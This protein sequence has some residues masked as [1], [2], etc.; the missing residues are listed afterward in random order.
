M[1]CG[2][3]KSTAIAESQQPQTKPRA[4][5][6]NSPP[7][8]STIKA[9]EKNTREKS[10]TST[11]SADSGISFGDDTP[12]TTTTNRTI[13]SPQR[14]S[15]RPQQPLPRDTKTST[16]GVAFEISFGDD[17]GA[18]PRRRL[19]PRLK[20]LERRPEREFSQRDI[21]AKLARADELRQKNRAEKAARSQIESEKVE[22]VHTHMV[23][24]KTILGDS[25]LEEH[26]VAMK[27]R[28]AHL[29]QLRAKLQQQ[30]GRNLQARR[31]AV[32]TH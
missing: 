19:P 27:E 32:K 20:S 14:L 30:K 6:E 24:E 22:M 1:G 11:R 12:T 15:Q 25:K 28:E 16:S 3:S 5:E 8:I 31:L 18:A 29:Q 2:S 21:A 4:I 13:P 7:E 26:E 17:S 10:A 23:R 9:T